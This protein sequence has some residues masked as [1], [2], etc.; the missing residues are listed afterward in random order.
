MSV[1]DNFFEI[2]S[3]E[4]LYS[5]ASV[6]VLLT[7]FVVSGIYIYLFA[8]KKRFRTKESLND[9][10][11][12]WIGDLL[13]EENSEN[14]NIPPHVFIA[15]K[16]QYLREFVTEKLIS[17]K[18][19]ISGAAGDSIEAAYIQLG[20]KN[21]SIMK[22][23]SVRWFEKARG[24]YELYM[25]DQKDMFRDIMKYTNNKNRYVRREAQAAI[26]GFAGFDGLVFLDNLTNPMYEWQQ[27]KLLEQLQEYEAVDIE[28]LG[29]WLQS[30]NVYVVQF[31]LKLAEI[32]Q[33]FAFH[34]DVVDCLS[35]DIE[36]IRR[37][38]IKALGKISNDETAGILRGQYSG[39]TM[40][41]KRLILI[42]LAEIGTDD[43]VNFLLDVL[44]EHDDILKLES[45]RAIMSISDDGLSIISEN[46]TGNEPVSDMVRQ[47][48]K[49]LAT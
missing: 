27:L 21:D 40:Y 18:K 30:D 48:K 24:I 31:T 43:D 22:M 28:H 1:H 33:Q 4:H 14:L 29:L 39:E 12:E 45:I 44:D 38:A 11:E 36:K 34:D 19:N 5:A 26:I 46:A 49:E 13:S 23:K 2:I 37:Q 8:K 20:L 6:F 9:V 17:I 3:P 41:N 42:Q 7:F 16:K 32:Y 10:L 15:V 47:V 25:M 35:H